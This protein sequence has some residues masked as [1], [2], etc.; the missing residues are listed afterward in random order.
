MS[1]VSVNEIQTRSGTWDVSSGRSY[2]RTFMVIT[3]SIYDGPNAVMQ[4]LGFLYGDPYLMIGGDSD[5]H[6]YAN[7]MSATQIEG[8]P[9]GWEV[10]V[11]YGWYNP[12]FAG[13]GGNQ[14]PLLM[15]IDVNWAY[16]DYEI[17]AEFDVNGNAIINTAYDPFDPPVMM[18]VPVKVLT[19]VRNEPTYNDMQADMYTTAVN[20]DLFAGRMPMMVRCLHISGRSQWHQ[21][22]GWYWQVT[23]EFECLNPVRWPNGWR[24][25][26]L[27][28]GLRKLSS[29][30]GPIK[31]V[32]ILA[33]GVPVSKPVPLDQ[34]G[35]P[36]TNAYWDVFQIY[37]ELPF[38]VFGFDENALEGIRSGF[39]GP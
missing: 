31:Q 22:A 12:D 7:Q 39:P 6:A 33:N 26:I 37:N 30:A 36:T 18:N 19:V 5:L 1:I 34:N 4:S 32:P 3:N 13:G 15:P 28:Q 8:D 10:T 20:S 38:Q 24:K 21:D 17:V 11:N 35:Q 25:Q 23:Y 29:G 2:V 27:N 9:L 14:N 16:R